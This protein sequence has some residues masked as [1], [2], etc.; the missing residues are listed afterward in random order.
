MNNMQMLRLYAGM[1]EAALD[2]FLEIL[3]VHLALVNRTVV[4]VVPI[5][6]SVFY[7]PTRVQPSRCPGAEAVLG[8]VWVQ[9]GDVGARTACSVP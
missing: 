2:Y 6:R 8:V 7:L 5:E 3:W 1:A 4:I 9:T